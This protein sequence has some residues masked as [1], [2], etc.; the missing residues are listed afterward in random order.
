MATFVLVHG[1]WHGAWCW[2]RLTPELEARGHAVIAMDLPSDEPG[3]SFDGYA[4][5]VASALDQALAGPLI[6]VGHSLA[7]LTI[8]LVPARR[9][10]DQLVYLCAMPP[11]PGSSFVEQVASEPDMLDAN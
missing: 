1:A 2:G 10:V 3:V 7:G 8:P 11:R 6:L 5:V 4:D 9:P